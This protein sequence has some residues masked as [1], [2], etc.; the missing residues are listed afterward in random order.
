MEKINSFFNS[1]FIQNLED[2]ELPEVKVSLTPEGL[3]NVA[4]TVFFVGVSIILANQ[5]IKKL[6]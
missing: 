5:I 1:Q 6:T 4:L 2:G 3:I